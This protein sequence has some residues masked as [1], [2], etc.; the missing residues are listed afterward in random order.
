MPPLTVLRRLTHKRFAAITESPASSS[1]AARVQLLEDERAILH[2]LYTYGHGIDYNLEREFL[3][4]WTDDAVLQWPD[5][6][7]LVGRDAIA[8]A[9]RA[10]T[11]APEVFHK[12]LLVEPRIEIDGDRARVD[13]YFVRLD[14]YE[15]G[16]EI[17]SFGRYRDVLVRCPDGRWR[18]SERRAERE[19]RR[20]APIRNATGTEDQ[21]RKEVS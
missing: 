2:T 5:R 18:F 21:A 20:W 11:H 10:H 14:D 4:C 13:C 7:P 8:A 19:A 1:L 16:P 15:E 6:P 3:D 12:H 9:F 17:R